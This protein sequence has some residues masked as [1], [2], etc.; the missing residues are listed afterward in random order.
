MSLSWV[1][2]CCCLWPSWWWLT[3]KSLFCRQFRVNGLA[4]GGFVDYDSNIRSIVNV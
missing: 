2:F 3:R 1:V 4:G